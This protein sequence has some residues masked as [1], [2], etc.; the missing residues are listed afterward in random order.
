MVGSVKEYILSYFNSVF[1]WCVYIVPSEPPQDVSVNSISPNNLSVT[2]RALPHAERNGEIRYYNITVLEVAT[3]SQS[4]YITL[5]SSTQWII[6]DLHPYY[7]YQVS[8]AAATIGLGPFS[9]DV[10]VRMP[11]AGI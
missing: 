2:W 10:T 3:A 1:P 4:W 9:H 5:N 7:S 6:E 11:E 8:V